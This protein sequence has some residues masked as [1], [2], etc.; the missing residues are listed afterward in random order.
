MTR[1]L[2][3]LQAATLFEI[4]PA[5]RLKC[6]NDPD[7]APAPLL[8]MAGCSEGWVGYVHEDVPDDA[9][10]AFAETMAREPSLT[11]A[12]GAPQFGEDYRAIIGA[13]EALTAHNYGP[14]HRIPRSR[15]VTANATVV[16]QGTPEGDALW[17][18]LQRD[19]MPAALV[20]A[21]FTDTSHLWEPWCVALVDGAIA[22]LAFAARK[23]LLAAEVGVYTLE[24]YRGRGLAGAVT[25]AWSGLLPRH[26]VLFYSTHR[27]NL[28]SQRVIAKLGLPYVG[29][30]FR[31]EAQRG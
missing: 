19:G 20:A 25:A 4:T 15:S 21:G 6:T 27:D 30:S 5:R 1:A 2:L 16:C 23:G 7:R 26:P 8:Y 22:A 9:A 31:I 29:E 10:R 17:T 13:A 18:T 28:A 3:A 11:A 24:H 12:G 14:I